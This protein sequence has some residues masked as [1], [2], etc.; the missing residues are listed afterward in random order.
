MESDLT[1]KNSTKK[2][3]V[4]LCVYVVFC[5]RLASRGSQWQQI[6]KTIAALWLG[7]LEARLGALSSVRVQ[8][9]LHTGKK[10]MKQILKQY[11]QTKKAELTTYSNAV[12]SWVLLLLSHGKFTKWFLSLNLKGSP[13]K[14]CG[15][16]ETFNRFFVLRPYRPW[17]PQWIENFKNSNSDKIPREEQESK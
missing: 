9:E 3:Y 14:R 7:R 6:V 2:H 1:I 13:K 15:I 11:L 17:G 10:K 4:L 12:H 8:R 16:T 5:K